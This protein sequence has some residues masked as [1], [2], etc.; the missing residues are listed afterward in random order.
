MK[1]TYSFGT[2]HI[3]IQTDFDFEDGKQL[4]P[5]VSEEIGGEILCDFKK[6]REPKIPTGEPVY[7]SLSVTVYQT[8]DGLVKTYTMPLLKTPAAVVKKTSGGY[9]CECDEKYIEYF[10]TSVNLLNSVG[11]EKIAFDSGMFIFH[12]SLV[13][14]KGQAFLFTGS[15]GSGKSTRAD[16]WQK[17]LD[18]KI[19]NGDKAGLYIENG[20][21]M[22]CGLPVAGSSNIFI[23]KSLPVRAIVVLKKAKENSTRKAD[24]T[25]A[26]KEVYYNMIVNKWDSEFYSKA[27]LFA[28][29]I[30]NFTNVYISECNLDPSSVQEQLL[31]LGIEND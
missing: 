20:S 24:F 25:G 23:K 11:I 22:A 14:Y 2:A 4:C 12:C 21:L 18:A 30:T 13:E 15:S 27:V 10:N 19:I 1:R 5:F 31:R 6:S 7:T 8:A 28:S 26:I 17:E 9:A 16:M 3:S 29:E